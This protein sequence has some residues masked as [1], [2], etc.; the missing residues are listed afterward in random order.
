MKDQIHSVFSDLAG[1]PLFYVE[2][3]SRLWGIASPD[4]DYDVRGFHLPS[5]EQYF[6]FKKHR[7]LIEVMDGDFDFVSYDL[8]K[9]FGLLAKSNPTVF[10]WIRAH[11]VYLNELPDWLTFQEALNTNYDLKALFYHYLSMAKGK[12]NQLV[13]GKQFTYKSVFYCLR[14][15]FSA[16]LASQNRIPAILID[17]LF[18]QFDKENDAL[19]LAHESLDQKKKQAEKQEIPP[20][21]RSKIT[22]ILEKYLT[23][24]DVKNPTQNNEPKKLE[25]ILRAY[26]YELKSSYYLE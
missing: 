11:I 23:E 4:S 18:T 10:E 17:E 21:L 26:S 15:L 24:L 20:M 14:G 8:D 19:K 13:N 6:D 1:I 5:K 3:G 2:S 7:D 16:D 12:F 25:A 9:M 22:T